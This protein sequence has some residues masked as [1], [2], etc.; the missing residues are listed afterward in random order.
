MSIHEYRWN[1]IFPQYALNG[2]IQKYPTQMTIKSN[3]SVGVGMGMGSDLRG[4]HDGCLL[5][6]RHMA[7]AL[8]I[9]IGPTNKSHQSN[10]M[11]GHTIPSQKRRHCDM[12]I[13]INTISFIIQHYIFQIQ[14]AQK[15]K[16]QKEKNLCG[17]SVLQSY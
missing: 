3:K 4:H 5:K 11:K 8:I 13:G 9:S 1:I 2:F 10:L 16:S 15:V 14:K 6:Q 17:A 12:G 7:W